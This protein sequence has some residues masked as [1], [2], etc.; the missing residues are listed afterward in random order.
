MMNLIHFGT[1]EEFRIQKPE[2]RNK[3]AQAARLR[4]NGEL[5]RRYYLFMLA[6]T[7]SPRRRDACATLIALET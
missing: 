4:N 5:G 7:R 6:L 1:P 2:A 3:V